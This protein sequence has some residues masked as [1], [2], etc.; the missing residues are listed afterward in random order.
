MH[1]R[2]HDES[3]TEKRGNVITTRG[4]RVFSRKLGVSGQCDALEFHSD[5]DG[6]IV[7]GWDG[8]WRPFPVEYK[9]GEPKSGSCDEAQL[10]GQAMCLEE[11]LCCHI[12]RGALFYGETKRRAPVEFALQLRETVTNSI[13]E[14]HD[15]YQRGQTPLV[16]VSKS[17]NACSMK[18]ICLPFVARAG[19]VSDYVAQRMGESL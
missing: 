5:N 2:V 10:C 1:E 15:L 9:R 8:K 11:M 17:C 4:V 7:N 13:K 18:D 16:K 14:M 19:K 3:L 12:E 6:I